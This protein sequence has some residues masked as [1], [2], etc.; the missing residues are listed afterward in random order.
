MFLLQ[1]WSL[2]HYC[3]FCAEFTDTNCVWETYPISS[4]RESSGWLLLLDTV[5]K[6]EDEFACLGMPP[7]PPDGCWLAVTVSLWWGCCSL[8]VAAKGT[9]TGPRW[10]AWITSVIRSSKKLPIEDDCFQAGVVTNNFLLFKSFTMTVVGTSRTDGFD[11]SLV[12]GVEERQKGFQYLL[13]TKLWLWRDLLP[14]WEQHGAV[15][16]L[17]G[18]RIGFVPERKNKD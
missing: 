13:K 4:L 6:N 14:K 16:A 18:K 7:P 9:S 17:T 8:R 11:G 1:V 15:T 5:G 10:S 2:K 12:A 3:S